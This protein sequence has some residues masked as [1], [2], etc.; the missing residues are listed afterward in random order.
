MEEFACFQCLGHTMDKVESR[1][2]LMSNLWIEADHI[3]MVEGIDKG[4]HM[5]Y[6]GEIGIGTWFI[7]LWLQSETQFV[8]PI[9][10][11]LTQE[12]D[13][14]AHALDSHNGIFAGF[15]INALASTPEDVGASP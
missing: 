10:H 9:N 2:M 1:H 5:P 6:G 15:G 8:S 7:W 14:A 13:S 11:I 4:Q 12:V 3:G